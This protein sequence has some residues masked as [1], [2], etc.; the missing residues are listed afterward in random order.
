M[1]LIHPG[2]IDDLKDFLLQ[3]TDAT[4]EDGEGA[5]RRRHGDF[6][7]DIRLHFRDLNREIAHPG[8]NADIPD[9]A[10]GIRGD[11]DFWLVAY[12]PYRFSTL[13]CTDIAAAIWPDI[14]NIEALPD[15]GDYWWT[16]KSD[17]SLEVPGEPFEVWATMRYEDDRD[18]EVI[19]IETFATADRA[20]AYIRSRPKQDAI[21]HE[22]RV[23][24]DGKRQP[25]K[26]Q[27]A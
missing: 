13:S 14:T 15:S 19:R 23:W 2:S 8:I 11:W 25:E 3:F 22:V 18:P 26:P 20:A 7:H 10:V 6:F 4:D 5:T 9:G 17:D 12:L 21:S 27:N 24:T 1:D 16:A